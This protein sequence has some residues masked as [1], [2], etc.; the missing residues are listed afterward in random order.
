MQQ[1]ETGRVE[2]L[3]AVH[4][5]L[6]QGLLADGRCPNHN[7]LA[8]ALGVE[9]HSLAAL[10]HELAA[11]H[12]VVLHPHEPEC[13]VVHPFS[14]T[15]TLH[16]VSADKSGWWAPCVWCAFGIATLAGGDVQIHTRL[17][18]EAEPL[19]LRVKDGYPD[20]EHSEVV[21]HFSM[22]PRAAWDNIHKHCALVLPFRNA[23]EVQTWCARHGHAYG[24][25]VP[26]QNVAQ[27]A[28]TWYGTYARAGW[29]KWTVEQAQ[30]IFHAAGLTS[31]FWQLGGSGIY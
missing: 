2:Q 3:S 20:A 14:T 30:E 28:R 16:W 25:A 4:T 22:P 27:L 19:V 29:R 13:W 24:E 17:G 15:P 10:L 7:Q 23:G 1:E 6:I 26:L 18:A 8:H 12:G 21:V 5:A 9:E 11:M 31:A